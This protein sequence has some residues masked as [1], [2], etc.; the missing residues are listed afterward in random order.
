MFDI[1]WAEMLIIGV[2]ALIVVGPKDLPK[3]FHTLGQT[4]GKLRGMAHEFQSAMSAAA[5]EAGVDGV[6]R[7][8]R[9]LSSGK[10]IR[11]AVGFDE[12]DREF[13]AVRKAAGKPVGKGITPGPGTKKLDPVP[14]EKTEDSALEALFEEEDEGL[15]ADYDRD[16]AARNA[17]MTE[18]ERLRLEREAR[19]AEARIIA[20][21]KRA[22]REAHADDEA[23]PQTADQPAVQPGTPTPKA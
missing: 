1:G 23:A 3:M 2:V 21:Q 12:I 22:L 13:D 17:A 9:N 19:S 10:T 4:V 11:E 8:M 18:T 14:V 16:V 7:D 6:A 20:A 5:K 15:A